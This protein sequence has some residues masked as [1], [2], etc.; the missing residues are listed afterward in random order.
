MSAQD[1]DHRVTPGRTLAW[2]GVAMI[3]FAAN[4]LLCRAALGDARIDAAS[5]TTVRILSGAIILAVIMWRRGS[6]VRRSNVDWRS[7]WALFIYMIFFSFAYLSLNAGTGALVLFGA[8]QLTMFVSAWRAGERFRW[9]AWAGFASAVFGLVYLI[10]PGI[11][12]PDPIGAGLMAIA[13]VAWGLY[14]LYGRT[15]D[16]PLEATSANFLF[17]VL[18][19]VVGSLLFIREFQISPQGVSLAIASGAIASGLGYAAWYTALRGLA[20]SHAAT[21]QL[22]VPVLAAIGGVVLLSEP[23]SM[24]LIVAAFATLGGVALVLNQRAVGTAAS[25]S[26]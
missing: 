11:E 20:A 23:M 4:S 7:V 2:T 19:S 24:R 16:N 13:G 9:S 14:S 3:A 18:L 10:S 25:G 8:V 1:F 21:V 6:V 15:S 5:F 26:E 12:A 22:S 17:A